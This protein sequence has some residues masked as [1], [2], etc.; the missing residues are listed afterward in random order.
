MAA[1][2]AIIPYCGA[3]PSPAQLL[4]RWNLDPVLLTSLVAIAALYVLGARRAG[5]PRRTLMYFNIGWFLTAAA[6]I[7]PLCPL[8]VSLF[9]ARVGQHM[10]LTLVAAPIVAL[11]RPAEAIAA[12][13]KT[14]PK[15]LFTGLLGLAAPTAFF[16]VFLWYWHTP[17][18]YEVTFDSTFVY[19][20]MHVT[21]Y[22]SALWLWTAILNDRRYAAWGILAALFTTVQMGLLGALITL[23]PKPMYAWHL[24]TT[25]AW[26]LTPLQDQQ[27][28]GAVMWAPGCIAF[29]VPSIIG[30]WQL[31]QDPEEDGRRGSVTA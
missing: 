14:R 8:S 31:L 17:G 1:P 2:T 24:V 23:A 12:L 11:G 25:W 3:P 29:L 27:L 19:W 13:L 30:F 28:G 5:L 16:A 7:S 9:T 10:I 15:P 21:L 20:T 18:P 22:G 26:G 4:M 6:L